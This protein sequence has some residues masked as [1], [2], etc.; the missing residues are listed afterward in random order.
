MAAAKSLLAGEMYTFLVAQ[1]VCQIL[2]SRMQGAALSI[3]ALRFICD[4]G[5]EVRA[6]I[7]K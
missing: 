4:E 1:S 3:L 5:D 7:W 6:S 2:H